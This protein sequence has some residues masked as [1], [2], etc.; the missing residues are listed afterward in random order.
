MTLRSVPA[1]N[2]VGQDSCT[3]DSGG[4]MVAYDR[5]GCPFQVGVVSWGDP[6]CG[7][8]KEAPAYGVYTRTSQFADWIQK[9]TGPLTD[10]APDINSVKAGRLTESEL[11][12]G[13][14]Q[15]NSL[16]GS[17]PGKVNLFIDD[18]NRIRI[19]EQLTFKAR[20]SVAGRLA[21][22]DI[23]ADGQ[24]VLIFPNK[25]VTSPKVGHIEAGQEIS[26]P[27]NGSAFEAVEPVGK[28]RMIALVTPETF[29]IERILAASGVR[30]KG[31]APVPAPA[32]YFMRFIRQIE[33][34]I[35]VNRSGEP[36]NTAG[37]AMTVVD[38]E[39]VR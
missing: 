37:W 18:D 20:S 30:T 28:S 38:Y 22:I 29:Q 7:G 23:N 9:H 36:I 12:A 33:R 11:A 34:F 27:D 25:F 8:S 6:Q 3:G 19:G 14:A 5:N 35:G 17:A 1:M 13:L 15:L 2:R 39:I 4:P 32:N 31:F 24:V 21:L 10:A 16:L 26:V